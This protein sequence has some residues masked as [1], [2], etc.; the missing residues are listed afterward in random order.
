MIEILLA[1]LMWFFAPISWLIS[2]IHLVIINKKWHST[3]SKT[4]LI[5]VAILTWLLTAY[6]TYNNYPIFFEKQ[7]SY[8]PARILG[9]IILMIAVAIEIL[10]TKALSTRRVFGSSEFKEVRDQLITTG[11]YKYARHP[12][13]LEHPFWFLGLGLVFGYSFLIYFSIYLFLSFATTAYLEEQEL[14][15]RY[16][17]EYLDYKK[18]TPAFFLRIH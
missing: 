6:W 13:Y 7:F 5:T 10:T 9:A 12:R 4:A 2:A 3:S 8:L 18:Q 15:Q 11:I 14:I 17:Q 1:A 16:G